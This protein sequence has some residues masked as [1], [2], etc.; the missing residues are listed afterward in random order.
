MNDISGSTIRTGTIYIGDIGG[1]EGEY[2]VTGAVKKAIGVSLD[3][4]TTEITISIDDGY[5]IPDTFYSIKD[6]TDYPCSLQA[7]ITILKNQTS[8]NLRI[9]VDKGIDKTTDVTLHTLI[10]KPG[11][12]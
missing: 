2:P 6:S 12:C 1:N 4:K 7:S 5:C 9:I 10:V 11:M 8:T 3:G